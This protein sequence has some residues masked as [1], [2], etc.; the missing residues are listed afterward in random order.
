MVH[1]SRSARLGCSSTHPWGREVL[2]TLLLAALKVG[3]LL[4]M[5]VFILFVVNT[6][7]AD[8]FGRQVTAE[9]LVGA[10]EQASSLQQGRQ[11]LRSRRKKARQAPPSIPTRVAITTGRAA[12]SSAALPRIGQEII[13]GRAASCQLDIDDDYASSRHAKIWRD[14]EGFVVEDMLS[15]NGTYVNGQQITQPTRIDIGD[16]VRVGRTQMQLEA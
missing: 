4:L 6:V 5:W 2:S 8:L 3:F 1:A 10:G 7:R 9:E 12:G 11:Q 14:D 16:V 13:M 15:T